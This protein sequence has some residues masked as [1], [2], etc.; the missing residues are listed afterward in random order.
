MGRFLDIGCSFS[1]WSQLP[2]AAVFQILPVRSDRVV[3][4]GQTW[5]SAP[6]VPFHDYEDLHG[7]RCR[8]VTLIAGTTT[9]AYAAQAELPDAVDDCDP[10]APE[11]LPE[12]LPDDVLIYT[13]ASRFCLSDVLA[14]RAWALFGAMTP[15]YG[16]VEAVSDWV[17]HHLAYTTGSSNALSTSVDAYTSGQGVCRDFAHLMI[18]M[19]RALNIPARYAYGYLP[20]MDVPVLPTPMDF[21]AWVQVWLG[22]R[23]WDFDPRHNARRKGRVR[24]GQGR[25]AADCA[26]VTT[27]G[28]PILQAMTVTAHEVFPG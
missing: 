3:V 7:N 4:S 14:G 25:D 26:M 19:C 23:W 13:L 8:R 11:L 1:Y 10:T 27:Y 22:D 12:D 6:S 9:I 5:R 15:G 16:R 2:T 28:A 21:H 24:I 20:D 18:T 17:W